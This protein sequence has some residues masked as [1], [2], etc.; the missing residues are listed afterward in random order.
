MLH[1]PLFFTPHNCAAVPTVR[2]ESVFL[3]QQYLKRAATR[4]RPG[5]RVINLSSTAIAASRPGY[6]AYVASKAA[7]EALTRTFANE[8]RGRSV[9]V[10]AVALSLSTRLRRDWS[11]PVC[12]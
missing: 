9:T 7:V 4:I 1:L 6:G 12:F 3:F 11:E 8:M 10:N 2:A 5:G